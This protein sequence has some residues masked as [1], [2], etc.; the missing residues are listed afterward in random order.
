[1]SERWSPEGAIDLARSRARI[2]SG[3]VSQRMRS[4]SPASPRRLAAAMAR[5][6]TKQRLLDSLGRSLIP[7]RRRARAAASSLARDVC[8][9]C[10]I[11]VRVHTRLTEVRQERGHGIGSSLP[12]LA[13]SRELPFRFTA[14]YPVEHAICRRLRP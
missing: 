2:F 14:I 13:Q 11:I 5:H 8:A 7:L 4:A 12:A 9:L 3:H 6:A 10:V 1:M